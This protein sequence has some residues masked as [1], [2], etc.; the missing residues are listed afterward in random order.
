MSFV[1]TSISESI[2]VRMVK[3]PAVALFVFPVDSTSIFLTVSLGRG[4]PSLEGIFEIQAYRKKL[5]ML[6]NPHHFHETSIWENTEGVRFS[7]WNDRC[8]NWRRP[9]RRNAVVPPPLH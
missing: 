9:H 5:T 2:T 8:E 3:R 4:N 1:R 6:V 7:P